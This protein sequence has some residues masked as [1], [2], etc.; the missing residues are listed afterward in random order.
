MSDR[1]LATA[2]EQSPITS[3]GEWLLLQRSAEHDFYQQGGEAEFPHYGTGRRSIA[4]LEELSEKLAKAG[5]PIRLYEPGAA[6]LLD[7]IST[8]NRSQGVIA[9]RGAELANIMWMR[10][11]QKV[12]MVATPVQEETHVSW[13][14]AH[15]F[16][17]DF[18]R[19]TATSN[20]PKIDESQTFKPIDYCR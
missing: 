1:F 11:G 14:L 7:Q 13:N 20:Y 17:V 4:N 8:F 6:D 18:Y 15:L 5:I 16:G 3:N 12:V 19:L 9:I 10:P 2:S